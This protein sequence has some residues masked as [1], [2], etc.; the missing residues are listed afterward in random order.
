M[1]SVEQD[2]IESV[3]VMLDAMADLRK[4]LRVAETTIRRALRNFRSERDIRATLAT[5]RPADIRG[6]VNESL[7]ELEKARHRWRKA[8][9]AFG[10]DRGMSIA[11]LAR[12]WGFSRQ[13]AT[14]Y[15]QEVRAEASD[16]PSRQSPGSRRPTAIG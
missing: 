1:S 12:T 5:F 16:L 11:D 7:T 4:S 10:L 6:S 9:F 2:A 13:L 3:E 8:M 14:K 15:A